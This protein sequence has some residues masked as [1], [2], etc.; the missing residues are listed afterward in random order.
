M[1]IR[2]LAL[3]PLLLLGACGGAMTFEQA[4][5]ARIGRVSDMGN[6]I[7][8]DATHRDP[9][10]ICGPGMVL[11]DADVRYRSDTDTRYDERWG[12]SH[13]R[14]SANLITPSNANGRLDIRTRQGARGD[15]KCEYLVP[16]QEKRR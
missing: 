16:K 11:V 9:A 1:K 2:I 6:Q 3:T 7:A 8:R 13:N 4:T 10:T 15:W 12:E 5:Q 14:G